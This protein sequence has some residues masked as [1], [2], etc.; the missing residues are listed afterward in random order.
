MINCTVICNAVYIK[1]YLRWF[2]SIS[3]LFLGFFI[4]VLLLMS[5]IRRHRERLYQ[6]HAKVWFLILGKLSCLSRWNNSSWNLYFGALSKPKWLNTLSEGYF[7]QVLYQT[8]E[9]HFFFANKTSNAICKLKFFWCINLQ[10]WPCPRIPKGCHVISSRKILKHIGNTK[11]LSWTLTDLWNN[12]P[13]VYLFGLKDISPRFFTRLM[14]FPF[15]PTSPSAIQR[16]L[17]YQ[18]LMLTVSSCC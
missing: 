1:R 11:Q 14:S 8:D 10:C 9:F 17:M 4:L 18:P 12:F 5:K 15:L 13:V 2:C 16:F 6:M 7:T 3:F